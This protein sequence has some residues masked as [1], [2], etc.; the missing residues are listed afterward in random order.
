MKPTNSL[1]HWETPAFKPRTISRAFYLWSGVF[2]L[3]TIT[4]A[5]VSNSPI[6][7]ITFILIGIMGFITLEQPP[8]TL[9]CAITQ[10]GVT[11][12]RELYVFDNIESFW[13]VYDE[14][15]QYISLKTNGKLTPFVHIP[16]G[17]EDP[18]AIHALLSQH[19][20]EEK[21]EPTL[22]DIFGKMLHSG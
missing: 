4:Y 8:H 11:I 21:H 15:E 20:R 14:H 16:I 18:E 13:I 6:M 19:A 12:D 5:L 10:D 9:Q 1:L 3:A 17:D 22:L 2:L 7:A